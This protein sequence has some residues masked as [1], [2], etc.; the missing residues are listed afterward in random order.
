MTDINVLI[1]VNHK[2][3]WPFCPLNTGYSSIF[4]IHIH[5]TTSKS[6]MT[7]RQNKTLINA[8]VDLLDYFKNPVS[9][10]QKQYEVIRAIAVGGELIED[11]AKRYGYKA[12]TVYSLLRDARAGKIELF[13]TVKKGP[14]QKRT[15]PDVCDKIIEYRKMRLSASD[16][17]DRLVDDT[18][19]ISSR[20][21]ERI[22]K[23]AGYGKLKRRTNKELGIT[24]KNK[25]I[26]DRSEHL[27][28]SELEP[29]NI[30]CPLAGCFFFIPYILESG[31]IDIVK[32]CGM[33]DSSDIGSTQACLSML[34]LKLMGRKRL[35]HI[36]TYDREPGLG[37]F[38]GLNVLPKPTYMNT[39]SCR[40]SESQ[41]MN[42]QSKVISGLR[43][44]YPN[45]YG[46]DYI[47]LD[48]HSIPHY[49]D[50]SEMEKVWCGARGKTMKG[51]NT[52]FVQD[53]SVLPVSLHEFK[54]Y[55]CYVR[56]SIN[57]KE[58]NRWSKKKY[59]TQISLSA[60][61]RNSLNYGVKPG[62]APNRFPENCG[63]RLQNSQK[64]IPLIKYQKRYA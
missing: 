47:D 9:H 50:E 3:R 26:P 7:N 8:K 46:S 64:H 10:R 5:Q 60:R 36:G 43:K 16:I 4:A 22:L 51:A 17:Q 52:V 58:D 15:K 33:P 49:G 63:T 21:V 6:Q 61:L 54:K 31:I 41:V 32:E 18:N 25:I 27:D 28:F 40:C 53:G 45:L 1:K 13:P 55:K 14:Q 38:A 39:Y 57:K 37:I 62:K 19:K 2:D 34:L 24:T 12:T 42:L 23:D 56:L 20:T 48:F 29:F 35:S 44:K 30:D 11:A 59:H